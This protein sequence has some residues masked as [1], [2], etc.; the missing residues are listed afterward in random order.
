[1][2]EILDLGSDLVKS[3]EDGGSAEKSKLHAH[4]VIPSE[5]NADVG[6]LF[7]RVGENLRKLEN[8]AQKWAPLDSVDIVAQACNI[9]EAIKTIADDLKR[10]VSTVGQG[11]YPEIRQPCKLP[12]VGDHIGIIVDNKTLQ[13]KAKSLR[14]DDAIAFIDRLTEVHIFHH[15][16]ISH[17]DLFML[18]KTLDTPPIHIDS[19]ELLRLLQNLVEAA[20]ELPTNLYLSGVSDEELRDHGGEADIYK[21]KYKDGYVAARVVRITPDAS[22]EIRKNIISVRN[23]ASC[24][25]DL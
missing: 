18:N 9:Y 13:V 4:S 22:A 7:S 24:V 17:Q 21:C 19:S 12:F 16:C 23:S 10:H 6:L 5:S 11:R 2:S 1:M 15:I 14:G 3:L 8:L 20:E 25:E